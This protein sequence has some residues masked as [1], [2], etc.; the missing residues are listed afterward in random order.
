VSSSYDAALARLFA[1][2][3]FGVRPGLGP[4]EDALAGLG[5]PERAFPVVHIAGTN[6]KGSTAAVAE[7]IVHASGHK[8]GLYT[9]PHLARFTERFRIDGRELARDEVEPLLDEVSAA[10]PTL[11]F[12][13]VATAMAL[14]WF[15][16]EKVALAIVEVGL[17][18]RLD[19][20]NAIT[21][22]LVSIIT[23]ISLDHTDVLGPTTAHI[24]REKAGILRAGVPAIVGRVDVDAE[25]VIREVAARVGAELRFLGR[26]FPRL[27]A[28]TTPAL[29][30][31]HQRDNAAL[32][33]E[34]L[35]QLPPALRPDE[36]AIARGLAE[37][38]WPGR[39]EQLAD[40]LV[41]DGAHN[42][43]GAAALAAALPAL[44]AGRPIHLVLGVVEDKDAAALLR[45]LRPIVQRIVATRPPNPR[46]L[47]AAALAERLGGDVVAIE[48]PMAAL[49]AARA[50]GALTVVAG[51]LFL[52]G[53][54]RAMLLGEPIDPIAAQDPPATLRRA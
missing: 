53:W 31:E 14:S 7:A 41:L 16:R 54:L 19:A 30:G 6:G 15:A 42:P 3:R 5:H 50:P 22:P 20:T 37:A 1:L 18:G 29:L 28:G 44:A 40:D 34:A 4:I 23:S 43:D 36:A 49:A 35:R 48:D 24:A 27:A 51:S 13:E 39:L 12:F 33:V 46:G 45:P 17:G 32:A 26:D 11:T 9:S 8:V 52:V 21:R 38:H 47:A 10:G 25:R 2:R